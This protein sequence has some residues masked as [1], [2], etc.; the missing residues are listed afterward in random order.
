MR[1][2]TADDLK[3]VYNCEEMLKGCICRM[4]VTDDLQELNI[5]MSG[6]IS[7]IQ[8]IRDINYSRLTESEEQTT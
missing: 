4:C 6:A 1:H 8:E 2:Q 7:L 3:R 5:R